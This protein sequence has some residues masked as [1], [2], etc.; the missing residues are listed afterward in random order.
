[1]DDEIY[2]GQLIDRVWAFH[3]WT[4][5]RAIVTQIGKLVLMDSDRKRFEDRKLSIIRSKEAHNELMQSQTY[6]AIYKHAVE[7]LEQGHDPTMIAMALAS[8]TSMFL[9]EMYIAS[10]R[11]RAK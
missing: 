4:R 1:M 2:L 8:M 9:E 6:R 3:D 5:R 7:L 10:A 11:Q